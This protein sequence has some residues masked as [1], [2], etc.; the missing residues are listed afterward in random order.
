M[1]TKKFADEMKSLAKGE[2]INNELVWLSLEGDLGQ[3]NANY[4][5]L[6]IFLMLIHSEK[7]EFVYE[8]EERMLATLMVLE[9][10]KNKQE[11]KE[12]VLENCRA[13]L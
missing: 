13:L 10:Y 8:N 3:D 7:K 6:Q 12:K 2:D 5:C 4:F 11:K 9:Y 1:N